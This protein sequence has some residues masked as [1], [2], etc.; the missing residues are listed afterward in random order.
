MASPCVLRVATG[1]S[2]LYQGGSELW[3]L[4]CVCASGAPTSPKRQLNHLALKKS[5]IS[6]TRSLIV[7]LDQLEDAT[8]PRAMVN[9]STNLIYY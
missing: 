4:D 2:G 6:E 5:F 8:M 7:I 9:C 1:G 3:K